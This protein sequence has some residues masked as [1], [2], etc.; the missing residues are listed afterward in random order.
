MAQTQAHH[1]VAGISLRNDG[2]TRMAYDDLYTWVIWQFPR[3]QNGGLCG[4]VHPPVPQHGWIPAV[5]YTGKKHLDIYAHLDKQFP[6]PEL[7]ADYLHSQME[8]HLA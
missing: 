2:P 1:T 3:P 5:I 4:A 8:N 6:T 7:A